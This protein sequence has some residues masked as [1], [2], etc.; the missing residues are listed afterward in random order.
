MS[1]GLNRLNEIHL[2]VYGPEDY[3]DRVRGFLAEERHFSAIPGADSTQQPA[4]GVLLGD[5]NLDLKVRLQR[6]GLSQDDLARHLGKTKGFI[7]QLLS[8]KKQW[9]EGMRERAEAFIANA[10][11]AGQEGSSSADTGQE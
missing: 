1:D 10:R 2:R 7:S 5:V 9:P 8:G 4:T 11:L 3:L 6:A